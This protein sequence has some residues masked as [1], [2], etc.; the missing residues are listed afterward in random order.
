[1]RSRRSFFKTILVAL[2]SVPLIT[3][4]GRSFAS[5]RRKNPPWL[6]LQRACIITC[7]VCSNAVVERMSH[8]SLKGVFHCQKC[9]TWLAPKPGD[10][11]IYESYGS[12]RCPP[13]QFKAKARGRG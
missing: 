10:H 13:L 4:V 7:P 3:H 8:E 6:G 2:G 5:T 11:C 1:M 12:V 9:L